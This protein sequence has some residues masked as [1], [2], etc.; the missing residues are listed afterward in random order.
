M[1]IQSIVASLRLPIH[2]KLRLGV[3]KE[4]K[5]GNPYPSEVEFF[6][7]KDAPDVAK[8]YGPEPY[9]LDGFFPSDDEEA[10]LSTY[11]RS[12]SA[13]RKDSQG[14]IIGGKLNCEGD[15]PREDIIDGEVVESP[16]TARHYAMRDPVTGVV[17]A[18]P[19]LGQKCPDYIAK[20]CKPTMRVVM[21]LPTV[22]LDGG[23]Q[24]DTTSWHS[25]RSFHE[26]INHIKNMNGG[27]FKFIPFKIVR[28]PT[29]T[30]H[31]ENGEQ[32]TQ[33][34]YIM[35]LK[36]NRDFYELQGAAIRE[37]IKRFQNAKYSLTGVVEE[38]RHSPME[39][40]FPVLPEGKDE[41]VVDIQAEKKLRAEELLQDS[42]VQEAFAGLERLMNKKFD[43][44][45]R[46]TAVRKKEN[47]PDPKASVL[48]E[49]NGRIASLVAKNGAQESAQ[50]VAKVPGEFM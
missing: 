48:T 50:P 39:D 29:V 23:F 5:N 1:P 37:Q 7:T 25:I 3:R 40:H 13:G 32:K 44:K 30:T 33:T 31:W 11:Y 21:I 10:V 24:I 9:E 35:K 47:D 18:R 27:S 20:K 8:V 15:G 45:A 42:E 22:T 14:N 6:V 17:P 38:I 36:P 16:G 26:Q 41:N 49:L 34:H 4:S 12:F 46:L 43:T 28:E 2:G 19:C